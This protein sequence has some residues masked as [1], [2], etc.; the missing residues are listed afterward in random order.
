MSQTF[1]QKLLTGLG[2]GAE[3]LLALRKYRAEK[4]AQEE[5]KKREEQYRQQ[6][7]LQNQTYQNAQIEHL[8]AL[9]QADKQQFGYNQMRDARKDY[10]DQ[11]TNTQDTY[12]R[13]GVF[14]MLDAL[15]ATQAREPVA[16][17]DMSVLNTVTGTPGV[18]TSLKS[19]LDKAFQNRGFTAADVEEGKGRANKQLQTV[20]MAGGKGFVMP[21]P[22]RVALHAQ[23]S[24]NA[25]ARRSA[26]FLRFADS[27]QKQRETRIAKAQADAATAFNQMAPGKA[28]LG[29]ESNLANLSPEERQS[30]TDLQA[31]R[32]NYVKTAADR[33][34]QAFDND[35]QVTHG[36]GLDEIMS[37]AQ[38]PY[39][40]TNGTR[41]KP[42]QPKAFNFQDSFNAALDRLRSAP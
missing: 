31:Y 37:Q 40:P 28:L 36:Y 8:R 39:M 27:Q 20:S 35:F 29:Y 26:D 4:A 9:E 34:A 10:T 22:T 42:A 23:Q 1:L 14:P 18:D 2:G 24:A 13:A 17:T 30:Y 25:D 32:D 41:T 19:G 3:N 33:A 16:Q 12:Q 7:F 15:R 5:D 6:Q 21:D 11:L 38:S